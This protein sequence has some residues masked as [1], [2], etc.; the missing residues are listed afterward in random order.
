MVF[1]NKFVPYLLT[2]R[3]RSDLVQTFFFYLINTPYCVTGG[4]TGGIPPVL[5]WSTTGVSLIGAAI[6]GSATGATGS[7]I[8]GTV[9]AAIGSTV[10][11]T[12][13]TGAAIGSTAGAAGAAIAGSDVTGVT[14][15]APIGLF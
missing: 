15:A 5:P 14:G 10:G 4:V 6:G 1:V 9:L 11:V 7:G 8:A 3:K 12:G 2:R 13:A